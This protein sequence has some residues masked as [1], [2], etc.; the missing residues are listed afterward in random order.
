MS[1]RQAHDHQGE[2]VGSDPGA[3][4]AET[5]HRDLAR[6]AEQAPNELAPDQ[7]QQHPDRGPTTHRDTRIDPDPR[8]GETGE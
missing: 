5:E 8:F 4:S 2:V 7:R 3:R 1:D 6:P